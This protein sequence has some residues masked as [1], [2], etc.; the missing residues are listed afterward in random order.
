[1][2]IENKRLPYRKKGDVYF[3][4]SLRI[5]HDYLEYVKIVNGGIKK[6]FMLTSERVHERI[7]YGTKN[8]SFNFK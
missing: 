6:Y 5:L 3:Y 1:M 8:W 7:C 4:I 2:L